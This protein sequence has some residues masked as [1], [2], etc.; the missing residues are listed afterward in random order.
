MSSCLSFITVCRSLRLAP[1]FCVMALIFPLAAL[2]QNSATGGT[3]GNASAV[4]VGSCNIVQQNVAA[5]DQATIIN[6]IDCLPEKPED[7]FLL[8]YLWLDA[9]T[10]SFLVAGRFDPALARLLPASPVVIHNPVFQKLRDVVDRFGRP[11][12]IGGTYSLQAKGES[13]VP[14][15]WTDPSNTRNKLRVYAAQQDIVWPDVPALGAVFKTTEWPRNYNMTYAEA[16]DPTA[17]RKPEGN[18]DFQNA[19]ISC[20]RLHVP[21]S[22]EMLTNY[23]TSMKELENAISRKE[24]KHN[25][26]TNIVFNDLAQSKKDT[27]MNKSIDAMLYFGERGWPEDFLLVFGDASIGG[28]GEGAEY[29]YSFGFYAK[30]R[31]LFTLVA[32]I[33][34]RHKDLQIEHVRYLADFKE[35]LRKLQEG[36]EPQNS[37]PGV[38][39]VKKGEMAVVPLRIEL[40]YD[41]DEFRPMTDANAAKKVYDR[42]KSLKLST[43]K[44]TGRESDYIGERHPAPPLRT[45]FSKSVS[46]FRPPEAPTITRTYVFGP[47]F[48][49]NTLRIKGTDVAVRKAPATAVA[50]LGGAE[51]GSCPF[52]FVSNGVDDPSRMG[53]VLIGASKKNLARTEEIKLPRETLSF[54]I[55]EQEPE[56]TF[57]DTVSVKDSSSGAERLIVSNVVLHPGDAREFLIPKEFV[58]EITLKLRGYYEPLRLERFVD[59][60]PAPNTRA[61][62]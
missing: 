62:N 34:P 25:G 13:A 48:S 49:L 30:P 1:F 21:I 23:W 59:S 51:E 53:R 22:A 58:G 39:S 29:D 8:R 26:V 15:E 6:E 31:K 4:V 54:F 14:A 41:L 50:Y 33:E 24:L 47:A 9:T 10:S 11:D 28:C 7:S 3:P 5:S 36:G 27:L 16:S 44:F 42:I 60:I 46:S 38:I 40:R 37:P 12:Q 17:W 19:A 35:Q 56:V 52:L 61:P 43:V 18:I 2:A 20:V 55:S 32:V 45:V 57:L